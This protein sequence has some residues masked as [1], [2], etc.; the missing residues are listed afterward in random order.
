ME[1]PTKDEI[2]DAARS[3]RQA[4]DALKKLFPEVFSEIVHGQMYYNSV[5]TAEG[6]TYVIIEI[7]SEGFLVLRFPT[8]EKITVVPFGTTIVDLERYLGPL[9]GPY[10]IKS[11]S[12]QGWRPVQKTK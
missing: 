3:S 7:E 8:F 10:R 6:H 5:S 2:F 4:Y 12:E 11:W 9:K 1:Y